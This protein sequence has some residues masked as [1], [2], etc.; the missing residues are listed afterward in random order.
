MG[1][2]IVGARVTVS[3][4]DGG[5]DGADGGGRGALLGALGKVGGDGR[6]IGGHR[7]VAVIGAPCR[8][9]A[10]CAAVL[11]ARVRGSD[12]AERLVDALLVGGGDRSCGR[13]GGAGGAELVPP[14]VAEL[15][16][17]ARCHRV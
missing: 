13:A 5:P 3:C 9:R 16:V 2:R 12:I 14:G 4:A 15:A 11:T 10:P 7:L 17:A 6:R 8:P 1:G